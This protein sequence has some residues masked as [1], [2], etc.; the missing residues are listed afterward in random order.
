MESTKLFKAESSSD[1]TFCSHSDPPCPL[2]TFSLLVAY[3]K[4][5]VSG[6]EKAVERPGMLARYIPESA[7]HTHECLSSE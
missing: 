1:T 6:I 2:A 3:Y 5:K 4:C 7:V